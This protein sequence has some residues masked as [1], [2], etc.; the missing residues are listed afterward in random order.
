MPTLRSVGLRVG[1]GT[2][3]PL[4]GGGD[5]PPPSSSLIGVSSDV[6]TLT[7]YPKTGAV[8]SGDW[9]VDPASGTNG[10]GTEGD[11]FDNLASAVSAASVDDVILIKAGTLTPTSRFTLSGSA[12]NIYNYGTDRP[13][14]DC[15]ALGSTSNAR[16]FTLTSG[17]HH[18]KGLEIIDSEEYPI[19]VNSAGNLLEDLH[20]H[21][22]ARTNFYLYGPGSTGNVVQDCWSWDVRGALTA[23]FDDDNFAST[24]NSGE[25][26]GSNTFV[27][28]VGA[29]GP[30]DGYDFYRGT[31]NEIKSCVAIGAGYYSN[32]D[33]AGD[34]N[35]FKMGGIEGGSSVEGSIAV[36]VKVQGFDAN[37][38]NDITFLRNTS[39]DA[40]TRGFNPYAPPASYV[41]E[42]LG[43]DGHTGTI[44]TYN[45]WNDS[46]DA[47]SDAAFPLSLVEIDFSDPANYDYS[48]D[49]SSEAIG[50]GVSGGNL[51]ASTEALEA[52]K[53][54]MDAHAA[55]V[56][57]R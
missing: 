6:D 41:R 28:C 46:A 35:G 42:N 45:S 29:N 44:G 17:G 23:P 52:L 11:P 1:S 26:S 56:Y 4:G 22:C 12:L 20:V 36:G 16:V 48:L 15:S 19:L 13:V 38:R 54:F 3:L 2:V 30:D 14:I 39:V 55:S 40:G 10:V 21:G 5:P 34:G 57:H 9:F 27:R 33:N 7:A 47:G 31:G 24:A 18:I 53:A 32:G 43:P 8:T 37:S 51:G 50:A 49:V 25:A